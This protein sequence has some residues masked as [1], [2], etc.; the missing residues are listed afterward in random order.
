[1][2]EEVKITSTTTL[3]DLVFAN[4]NKEYGAY[5]LRQVYGKTIR[6]SA[7]LGTAL[8]CLGLIAPTIY[9]NLKPREEEQK[10]VLANPMDIPPPPMDENIPPPPPPPPPPEVPQVSTT[11]FLPPEIKPDEEVPN[12]EP[13]PTQE[14][15]KEAPAATVTVQGDPNATEVVIDPSEGTGK[16]KE[17]VVEVKPVE[18]EVFTVVEQNAEFPGGA[19]EL[20]KFLQKNLKYPPAA[21]RANVQGKVFLSFVVGSD[22]RITDVS[23][24][25]G[26]GFGCDEEAVRVVKSMP[27]WNPGKQSGRAVKSRFNL[28]ISFV[29]E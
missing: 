17:E 4:R 26:L 8:V 29:L 13:P 1:M 2:A 5:F 3:E 22:G 19:A 23:V 28:P 7:L 18:E 14:E 12:D 21:S 16:V 10:V 11:K 20:G 24:L 6:N 15:L 27:R 25:K 9:A